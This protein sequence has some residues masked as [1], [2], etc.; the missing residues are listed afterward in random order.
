MGVGSLCVITG[1]KNGG[2]GTAG[3]CAFQSCTTAITSIVA[4]EFDTWNNLKLHDPKQ[5]VSR[6]WINATEFVGYN[7]NHVAIFASD[8]SMESDHALN[9]HFAATPSIPNL[10]DGRNHTVLIKYW[11]QLN[12]PG[13]EYDGS[14]NRSNVNFVVLSILPT[15]PP[16]VTVKTKNL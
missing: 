7:D 15:F 14:Y 9:E 16:V 2:C 5:G 11:P 12:D 13:K 3:S 10:A 1:A 6:W 8:G 4:I